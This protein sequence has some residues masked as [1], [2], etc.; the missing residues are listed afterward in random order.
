MNNPFK[1]KIPAIEIINMRAEGVDAYTRKQ[2]IDALHRA[3][4]D[5]CKEPLTPNNLSIWAEIYK[6][7]PSQD[8]VGIHCMICESCV[9]EGT[10]LTDT[11]HKIIDWRT[12]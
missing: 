3:Q 12:A 7:K 1:K 11:A 4:C 6:G 2:A 5:I 9:P 8:E 10:P